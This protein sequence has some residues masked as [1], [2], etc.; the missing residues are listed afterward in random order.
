M[1]MPGMG[2]RET[3]EKLRELNPDVRVILSTGYSADERTRELLVARRQGVRAEAVQ[4]G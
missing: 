2:G 3:F 4:D 1:T